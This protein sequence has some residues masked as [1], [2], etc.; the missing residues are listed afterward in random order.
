MCLGMRTD[1]CAVVFMQML[2]CVQRYN[3][4]FIYA[5]Q[6]SFFTNPIPLLFRP[7]SLPVK[8]G[9]QV[10]GFHVF[11]HG[12]VMGS[13]VQRHAQH[14][15]QFV[16]HVDG[17]HGLAVQDFADV[18]GVHVYQF[19][20]AFGAQFALVHHVLDLHCD[21][22]VERQRVGVRHH[23]RDDGVFA[24]VGQHVHDVVFD[25]VGKQALKVGGNPV[26]ALPARMRNLQAAQHFRLL[27][28][29]SLCGVSG[30][31][32]GVRDLQYF[33]TNIDDLTIL[34]LGLR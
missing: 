12:V 2:I 7:C 33:F 29:W 34:L 4:F 27:V 24:H 26:L 22:L 25:A 14:D 17:R 28:G 30:P 6:M 32:H 20:E 16:E 13:Q 31:N 3:N 15:Q 21:A 23:E 1:M 19:A 8:H 18:G 5:T 11:R 10:G 9:T